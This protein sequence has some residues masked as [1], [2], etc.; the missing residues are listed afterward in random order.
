MY[1]AKSYKWRII[2]LFC[3]KKVENTLKPPCEFLPR[4]YSFGVFLFLSFSLQKPC[5]KWFHKLL[6]NVYLAK[7]HVWSFFWQ[8]GS[9]G[10][11]W[12]LMEH[13]HIETSAVCCQWRYWTKL[14]DRFSLFRVDAWGFRCPDGRQ[15]IYF[16]KRIPIFS[17]RQW[18]W[19]S[20]LVKRW[21]KPLVSKFQK[22]HYFWRLRH[23][24]KF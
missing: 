16:L 22:N 5:L 24:V 14:S 21:L 19:F 7:F 8:T 10:I 1:L 15:E 3:D 11:L 20:N 12:S 4:T 6:A 13:S 23:E 9:G 2:S 18:N 17:L